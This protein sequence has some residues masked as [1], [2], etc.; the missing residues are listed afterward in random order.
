M[1]E[2]YIIDDRIRYE[3]H[4]LKVAQTDVQIGGVTGA[5]LL[6]A[7]IVDTEEG[8]RRGIAIDSNAERMAW[9]KQYEQEV[10]RDEW[11]LIGAEVELLNE[12]YIDLATSEISWTDICPNVRLLDLAFRLVTTY[13]QYLTVET[14]KNHIWEY[15]Q[16]K[17]P[18]AQ[19]LMNAAET[20]PLRQKFFHTEWTDPAQVNDL[21]EDLIKEANDPGQ[22]L[23]RNEFTFVF[24]GEAA[25][26]IY[27]RYL[28]WRWTT[29]QAQIR[30]LPGAQP[31]AAKHRNYLVEQETDWLSQKEEIDS[32]NDD[33][34][35]LW[36]Q[37]M[38]NWQKYITKHLKPEKPVLFWEKEVSEKQQKQ[39]TQYLQ[40]QEKEWD[41]F[42]CL[43]AA[44]YALRQMGYVRRACSIRDITRW[45]TEQLVK[46]Y[47]TKNNHDQ[48]VRAWKEL[49]RY[50]PDVKEFVEEL[51][52]FG[53]KHFA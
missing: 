6:C 9:I 38:L 23:S 26:D 36:A 14:F 15:C 1:L 46:D 48:F 51:E 52:S 32:L 20:E 49:G 35:Q 28:T 40:I 21:Y 50:S 41:Y 5:A 22:T 2:D 3:N 27:K 44:I 19:W 42:Q 39:L 12:A 25:E 31:R 34:R 43:S 18:F 53:I 11:G 30:E 7:L 37:W 17:A 47:T 24:E 8:A 45:M 13:M 16:W 4:Y 29:Y 33:Q 10:R